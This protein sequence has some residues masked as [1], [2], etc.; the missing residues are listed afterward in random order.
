MC[1]DLRQW[2][3]RALETEHRA[4]AE[5]QDGDRVDLPD[6]GLHGGRVDGPA[7]LQYQELVS[8]EP[9]TEQ[10]CRGIN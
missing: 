10:I 8:L 4:K 9:E 1:D 2:L 5:Q 7:R 6:R 3:A